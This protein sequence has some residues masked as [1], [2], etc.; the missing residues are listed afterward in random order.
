MDEKKLLKQQRKALWKDPLYAVCRIL[1]IL[2]L[3]V[4]LPL[5]AVIIA[6]IFVPSLREL[7]ILIGGTMPVDLPG[8]IIVCLIPPELVVYIVLH[9]VTKKHGIQEK[10]NYISV[11][12]LCVIAVLRFVM[13]ILPVMTSGAQYTRQQHDLGEHGR[14]IVI[15]EDAPDEYYIHIHVYSPVWGDIVNEVITIPSAS[16]NYTLDFDEDTGKYVITSYDPYE[17]KDGE[18]VEQPYYF[19]F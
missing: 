11:I 12:G 2:C 19:K 18:I 10:F 14:M 4:V 1:H 15:S 8:F 3:V 17:S 7:Y 6:G 16:G 13:D 5:F 9:F